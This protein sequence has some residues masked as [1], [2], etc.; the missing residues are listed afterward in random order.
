M[1]TYT[2]MCVYIYVHVCVYMY[3]HTQTHIYILFICICIRICVCMCIYVYVYVYTCT[4]T[5][6]HTPANTLPCL[7][8]KAHMLQIQITQ[9]FV[10]KQ[11]YTPL[12]QR[13]KNTHVQP[14]EQ[15]A[16]ATN[17][18]SPIYVYANGHAQTKI[19]IPTCRAGRMCCK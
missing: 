9:V 7:P 11:T 6:I 5:D 4:K 2:Y 14:A 15:A 18:K 8:S 1:H 10:R 3:T 17:T 16:C 19:H 12:T 13:P